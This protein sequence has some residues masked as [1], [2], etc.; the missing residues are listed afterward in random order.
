M[1]QVA[2]DQIACREVIMTGNADQRPLQ[3]ECHV[4]DEAGLP[5]ASG[6]LQ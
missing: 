4:F 5:A 1:D 6:P 2:T 3:A